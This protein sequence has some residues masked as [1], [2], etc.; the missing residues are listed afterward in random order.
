MFGTEYHTK[1]RPYTHEFLEHM[2]ALF[3]MHI[4][5]YGQRQYAHKIAEVCVLST[6]S[7]LVSFFHG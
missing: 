7:L 4:I 1:L 3:E 5:T 2:S 6:T